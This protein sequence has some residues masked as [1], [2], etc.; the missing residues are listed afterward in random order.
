MADHAKEEDL[1]YFGRV[2]L[3]GINRIT[4]TMVPRPQMIYKHS[5]HHEDLFPDPSLLDSVDANQHHEGFTEVQK[6]LEKSLS[7]TSPSGFHPC[8]KTILE[9]HINIFRTW[10]CSGPPVT[11]P[12][13]KI[14]LSTDAK[15]VWCILRNYSQDQRK[16]RM[17][18]FS[19]PV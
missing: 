2:M 1:G 12:S 3:C 18:F 14:G 10:F 6:M 19:S 7:N 11:F 9:T 17:R 13:L 15:P 5:C 4:E 8:L 16:W